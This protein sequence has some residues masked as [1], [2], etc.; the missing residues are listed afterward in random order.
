MTLSTATTSSAGMD[1]GD[2]READDVAEDD[3]RGLVVLRHDVALLDHVQHERGQ[4]V[5]QE[6]LR[7]HLLV[8]ALEAADEVLARQEL[9]P[10][11]GLGVHD[12]ARHDHHD[13]AGHG[14]VQVGG[15]DV[16]EQYGG[17]DSSA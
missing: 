9:A 12:V 3:V 14:G 1:D 16:E 11:V 6:L 2:G 10:V 5:V 17:L 8:L 7:A 13:D 4:H 15:D